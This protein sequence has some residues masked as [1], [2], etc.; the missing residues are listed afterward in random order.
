MCSAAH[1][2]RARGAEPAFR[3]KRGV[4]FISIR[5]SYSE[6]TKS[7]RGAAGPLVS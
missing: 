5:I 7:S 4:G 1:R 3:P 2:G 6:Y